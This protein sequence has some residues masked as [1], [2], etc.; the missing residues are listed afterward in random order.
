MYPDKSG[1]R[2]ESIA[3][4][5]RKREIEEN[6]PRRSRATVCDFLILSFSLSLSFSLFLSFSLSLSTPI[7]IDHTF[8]T[9][10]SD[11]LFLESGVCP[12]DN[13][14]TPAGTN[15]AIPYKNSQY[16]DYDARMFRMS[17]K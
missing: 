4:K 5:N 6:A 13:V 15:I 3:S 1:A 7:D 16:N 17:T 14:N 9:R 11:Y 8:F 10:K 2:S 12:L